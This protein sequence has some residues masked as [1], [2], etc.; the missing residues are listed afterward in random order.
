MLNAAGKKAGID[1]RTLFTGPASRVRRYASP[2]LLEYFARH[3]RPTREAFTSG[4][5]RRDITY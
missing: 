2:E 1:E 4:R 3:G 5:Q